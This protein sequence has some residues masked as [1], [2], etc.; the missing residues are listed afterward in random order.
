MN[1]SRPMVSAFVFV[2]VVGLLNWPNAAAADNATTFSGRATAIQGTILGTPIGPLADT[3]EVNPSGDSLEAS[4]LE[5]PISGVPEPTNGALSAEILHATVVAHGNQSSA[6]AAAASLSLSA[7][8]QTVAADFLM[9]RATATCNGGTATVAG[10][11]ELAGLTLNG[12]SITVSGQAN[13]HVPLPDVGEITINEQI[14]D[15]SVSSGH[16]GIT[17]NAL[18][19]VITGVMDVTVASAHADITCGASAACANRDFVTGGGWIMTSSGSRANFGVAGGIKNGAFWGHLEYID[20]A[21]DGVR[22][23][24]TGV[25]NYVVTG[26]TSRQIDGTANVTSGGDGTYQVDVSDGGEPGA[27]VDWFGIAL[28][29]YSQGAYLGGGN[30]ALHCG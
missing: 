2:L 12:Q 6:E 7:A 3:G 9:A 22:A 5:Y 23:H 27:G 29:S 14:A 18:H 11:A 19:I 28:G 24:G 16:N 15:S 1:R 20:H 25:T 8:G 4:V 26:A 17:V 21:A 30:I 13:Q 10:S